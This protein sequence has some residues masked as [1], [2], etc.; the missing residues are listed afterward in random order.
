MPAAEVR[1][2]GCAGRQLCWPALADPEL[3]KSS[4]LG[5]CPSNCADRSLE[6]ESFVFG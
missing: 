4:A 3:M 6:V 2:E 5:W 1:S